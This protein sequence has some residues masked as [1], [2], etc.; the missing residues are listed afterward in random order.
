MSKRL[1]L[2]VQSR[3]SPTGK[4]TDKETRWRCATAHLG[5]LVQLNGT[6]LEKVLKTTVVWL[7]SHWMY[8]A[9]RDVDW[10]WILA[11]E[12]RQHSYFGQFHR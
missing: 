4:A 3:T 8:A 2:A 7:E 12:T 5:A 9:K 6:S 10:Q 11:D 1:E